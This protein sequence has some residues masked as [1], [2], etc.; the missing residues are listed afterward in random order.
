LKVRVLFPSQVDS[1]IGSEQGE[2]VVGSLM[3]NLGEIE[4]PRRGNAQRH[5]LL[6]ILAIAPVASVC[7]AESCVDLRSSPGTA[8]GCSGNSST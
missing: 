4:D 2:L 5:E 8:R 7:G 6:D 3:E 1:A